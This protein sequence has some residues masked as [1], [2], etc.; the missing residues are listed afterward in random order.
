MKNN[1]GLWW[2]MFLHAC[3]HV[4]IALISCLQIPCYPLITLIKGDIKLQFLSVFSNWMVFLCLYH[5]CALGTK[6]WMEQGSVLCLL[7]PCK[8][9]IVWLS[10]WNRKISVMKLLKPNYDSSGVRSSRFK[11]SVEFEEDCC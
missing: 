3:N 5:I 10:N 4:D 8:L 7:F 6:N 9:L 1:L 11:L 2:F